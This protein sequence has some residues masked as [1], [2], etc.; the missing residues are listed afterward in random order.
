MAGDAEAAARRMSL[1]RD[2]PELAISEPVT[3]LAAALVSAAAIPPKG[4]ADALHIA[5]AAIHGID[6]LLTWN[7]RHIDN[8]AQKPAIRAICLREGFVCPEICTPFEILEVY[9][10]EE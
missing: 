3:D 1:L 6:Y 4:Q 9:R 2:I 8:P 10:D 5:T 7:C